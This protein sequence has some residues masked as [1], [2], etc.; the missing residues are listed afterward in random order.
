[1]P[2]VPVGERVDVKVEVE[3]IVVGDGDIEED[4]AERRNEVSGM[5]VER[6]LDLRSMRPYPAVNLDARRIAMV[7]R[8]GRIS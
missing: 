8:G 4:A 6:M 2:S 1:M 5:G 3:V 7:S